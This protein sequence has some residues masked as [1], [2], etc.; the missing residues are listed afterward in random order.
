MSRSIA[1][2]NFL[3]AA[4]ALAAEI[5]LV[6]GTFLVATFALAGAFLAA[7]FAL[8]LLEAEDDAGFW[9]VV[10]FTGFAALLVFERALVAGLVFLMVL[11]MEISLG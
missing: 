6:A 7:V 1:S 9:R 4:F 10:F 2:F 5:F 8:V 11:A 3:A